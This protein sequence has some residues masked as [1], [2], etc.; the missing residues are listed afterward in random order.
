MEAEYRVLVQ[1]EIAR[2][3][4]PLRDQAAKML[5]ALASRPVAHVTHAAVVNLF[6]LL[7]Q[8]EHVRRAT[9]GG[10]NVW[11]VGVLREASFHPLVSSPALSREQL[12]ARWAHQQLTL[13]RM[14][15]E[16]GKDC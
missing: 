6:T 8:A 2:E 11:T 14:R 10:L 3:G 12:A 9:R 15:L 4:A 1:S 16:P 5:L 13:R 7:W